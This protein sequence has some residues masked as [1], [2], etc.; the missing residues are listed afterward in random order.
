M[1]VPDVIYHLTFPDDVTRKPVFAG[2]LHISDIGAHDG[3]TF[4]SSNGVFVD[5]NDLSTQNDL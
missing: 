5:E 4:Y 3:I 2:K 1:Y